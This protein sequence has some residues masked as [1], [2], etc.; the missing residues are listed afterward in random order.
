MDEDA[1]PNP[2]SP[3]AVS[4]LA[5]EHYARSLAPSFA[6]MTL[7][8][9]RLFNIF[10]PW[11]NSEGGYASVIPRWLNLCMSGLRPE[12]FGDGTATRDSCYVDD[13]SA[14]IEAIA[15]MDRR[16]GHAVYNIGAGVATSLNA[17]FTVI[18]EAV[19]ER[20]HDL[21]FATPMRAPERAS[22]ILHSCAE[23]SRA[24][25]DI[26]YRPRVTLH[27]GIERM[28]EAQYG[29]QAVATQAKGGR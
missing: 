26:D 22:D 9:L 19:R 18:A 21:D 20:G 24:M 4:K 11:Q 13:V 10:G 6:D 23:I 28:I 16:P 5:D 1:A 12:L 25:A 29:E 7:V 8:G 27:Q 17:L 15:G 2:L 14:A 3:Y